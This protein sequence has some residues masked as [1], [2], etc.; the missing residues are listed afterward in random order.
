MQKCLGE[1]LT[2]A[3][4]LM[5]VKESFR[6]ETLSLCPRV[7]GELSVHPRHLSQP[8][9]NQIML[10]FPP[11][12]AVCDIGLITSLCACACAC[13]IPLPP[14]I[15]GVMMP[16]TALTS[17]RSR[18][19]KSPDRKRASK[20]TTLTSCDTVQSWLQLHCCNMFRLHS[21]C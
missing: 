20:A 3:C 8:E 19:P 11:T 10:Q 16:D 4:G 2:T 14:I 6:P 1:R 9:S 7:S 17:W 12:G 18:R 5:V 21:S 15:S 13:R